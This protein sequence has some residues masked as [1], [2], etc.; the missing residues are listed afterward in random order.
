MAICT[1]TQYTQRILRTE[2]IGNSLVTINNNFLNLDLEVC[3]LDNEL[4]ETQNIIGGASPLLC[5]LR[6]SFDPTTPVPTT[7]RIGSNANRLYIHP[8]KGNV[9]SLYNT[10]LNKWNSF[11][12]NGVLNAPL[13]GL[14]ADTNYDVY[15]YQ[16]GTTFNIEFIA[17]TNNGPGE[18]PPTRAFQDNVTV[19]LGDKSKRFM[20]CLRTTGTPG[21]SEQSFVGF[22]N[23]GF[24]AKQYLWNNQS[25]V[26]VTS[27]GFDV[28]E[29]TATGPGPI[30]PLLAGDTGFRRAN[31]SSVNNGRNNRFSFI[32]GDTTAVDAV[33]QVYSFSTTWTPAIYSVFG[34]NNE[35]DPYATTVGTFSQLIGEARGN[36]QITARAHL[37]HTFQAGFHFIQLFERINT[38]TAGST[39]TMN[40]RLIAAGIG[41]I[42]VNEN[43]TG[44]ISNLIN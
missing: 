16:S 27:S 12:L 37:K 15:L 2:C 23:G 3:R 36:S 42:D 40:R 11:H 18:I 8:Y 38:G 25:Q 33:G 35:V 20:G 28:Q 1:G 43:K 5:G 14:A 6:L 4:V 32:I 17:W 7:N 29:Y 24:H 30:P 34:I 39:V 31:P 10:S 44:I 26:A 21:Q 19:R 9:F 22:N 41:G 13:A